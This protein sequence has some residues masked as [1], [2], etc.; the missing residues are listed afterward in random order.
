MVWVLE[1]AYHYKREQIANVLQII[2]ETSS[3]IVEDSA[4]IGGA[5]QVYRTQGVDFSDALL[6][7]INQLRGCETTITLDKKAS[8]IDTFYLLTTVKKSENE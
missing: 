4:R 3:F 5:L 6:G 7:E 8:K 1:S 2:L